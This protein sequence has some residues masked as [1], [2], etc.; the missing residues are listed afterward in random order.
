[1]KNYFI[2]IAIL[3]SCYSGH[4]SACIVSVP[5][6]Q[7]GIAKLSGAIIDKRAEDQ[8]RELSIT[9]YNPFSG[10]PSTSN[11]SSDEYGY[12]E[13]NIL[14]HTNMAVAF[15]NA[16][17]SDNSL[18]I[19]LIPEEEAELKVEVD[20]QGNV[21]ASLTNTPLNSF[22]ILEGAGL[23]IK[24]DRSQYDSPS[25]EWRSQY[26]LTPEEY[27]ASV[28]KMIHDRIDKV[29][30]NE[31]RLSDFAKSYL[32]NYYLL[33]VINRTLFY[34]KEEMLYNYQHMHPEEEWKKY[35][36]PAQPDRRYYSFLKDIGLNDPQYLYIPEYSKTVTK[37]LQTEVLQIPQI[38]ETS[39]A[40]WVNQVKSSLMDISG[41]DSGLFYDF[42]AM[43]AYG[44][45]FSYESVPLSN[46]QIDN[47]SN[48]FENSSFLNFLLNKNEKAAR[49]HDEKNKLTVQEMPE[50]SD[51]GNVLR[52][53]ILKHKGRI[54]WVDFWATWCGPCIKAI[55]E[56]KE[57]KSILRDKGVD[58][59]YL[60]NPTSSK[61][62]WEKRIKGIGGEHYFLNTNEWNTISDDLGIEG[63]PFYLLYDR[64]GKLVKSFVGYPG[65]ESLLRSVN[66]IK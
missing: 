62:I 61:S 57:I 25:L 31:H 41:V 42:L 14:V 24:M 8:R 11:S 20:E 4:A 32:S 34:Y 45:Q 48:Y 30:S 17:I 12:F 7:T 35:V 6:I 51:S 47:I 53:M 65:N 49:L 1:M 55:E 56:M 59:V 40:T 21:S 26:N 36:E 60:A 28:M 63:I 15:L 29:L 10:E 37:I 2:S 33:Y 18:I 38:G 50:I 64:E 23:F 16:G 58:F 3:I 39:I 9:I 27:Y 13:F 66:E 22:D 44:L 52:N 19:T 43:N 46:K 54:V 5:K